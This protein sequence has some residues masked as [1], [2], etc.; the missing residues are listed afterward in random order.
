METPVF[1]LGGLD[2]AILTWDQAY[3][4]TEGARIR[5]EIS[6]NGGGTYETIL[7]DTTGTATSGNYNNFGDRTPA[8]AH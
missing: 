8:K 5:V 4:L 2:E 7:F 3:N 1:S 6:T